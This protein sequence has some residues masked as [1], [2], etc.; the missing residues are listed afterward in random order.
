MMMEGMGSG[1]RA[2]E[3]GH[4][5]A[6]CRGRETNEDVDDQHG[7]RASE[8]PFYNDNPCVLRAWFGKGGKGIYLPR[9]CEASPI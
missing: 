5:A 2:G 1:R 6:T 4:L 3:E 9:R 7:E 8:Y